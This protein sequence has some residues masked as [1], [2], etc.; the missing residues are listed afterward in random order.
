MSQQLIRE[1][2][3]MRGDH[4]GV[5]GGREYEDDDSGGMGGFGRMMDEAGE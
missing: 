3:M 5:K 4:D 2:M 1:N